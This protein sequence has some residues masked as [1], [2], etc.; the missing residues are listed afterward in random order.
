[1]NLLWYGIGTII[2][3]I[4][5]TLFFYLFKFRTKKFIITLIILNLLT[6]IG[7]NLILYFGFKDNPNYITYLIIFEI[8]VIVIETTIFLSIEKH[9]LEIIPLTI[10]SNALSFLLGV[11]YFWL[12]QYAFNINVLS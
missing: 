10:S 5:E 6:N 4:S 2:T 1:M 12:L 7:I 3:I 11:F 8:L 9:H